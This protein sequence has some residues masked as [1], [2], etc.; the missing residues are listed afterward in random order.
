MK[1][2]IKTIPPIHGKP[3]YFHIIT[4]GKDEESLLQE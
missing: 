2:T 3:F 1:V 4:P